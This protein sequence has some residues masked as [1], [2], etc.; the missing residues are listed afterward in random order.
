MSNHAFMVR[1]AAYLANRGAKLDMATPIKV[2]HA[3]CFL[4]K[5]LHPAQI[6]ELTN[7]Q[8]RDVLEVASHQ[9]RDPWI[10]IIPLPWIYP[11][12]TWQSE[13]FGWQYRMLDNPYVKPTFVSRNRRL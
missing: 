8:I 1:H 12:Y 5:E 10:P 3:V 11:L 13:N 9:L 7:A 4:A 2:Y 6:L